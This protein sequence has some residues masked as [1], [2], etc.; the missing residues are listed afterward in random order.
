MNIDLRNIDF[1]DELK[2]I[3]RKEDFATASKC[4][5]SVVLEHERFKKRINDLE[6]MLTKERKENITLL[7]EKKKIKDSLKILRELLT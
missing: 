2:S 4:I 1:E 5:R 3:M 7:E 6:Q